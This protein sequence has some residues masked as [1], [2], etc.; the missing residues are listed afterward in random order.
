MR[1]TIDMP[2]S[3][4]KRVKLAAARRNTTFRALV[5]HALERTLDDMPDSFE[6]EDASTGHSDGNDPVNSETIN[7][8]IDRQRE[9]SFTQ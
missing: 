2:D 1:T 8:A 9:R 7:Q 5:V 3:L 6:L 4:M